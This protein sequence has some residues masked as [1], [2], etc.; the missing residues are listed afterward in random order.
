MLTNVLSFILG[1]A[2][3]LFGMHEMGKG[4]TAASGGKLEKILAKLTS[5]PIRGVLLGAA[6]TAIIQSSSAT[7]VMVVGFVNSGI[8]QLRQAVGVIMGANIGTTATSWILSL[9]GIEG[10]NLFLELCKPTS[11]S[12]VLAVI[13]VALVMFA[14]RER[15]Q[16]VGSILVG[17]A[18]LMTGMS[19][20]SDAV[21]PL[22]DVPEFTSMLTLF[23]NPFFGV[24]AGTLLT[25]IIQSSSASVGILQALCSTGVVTYSTALPIIMGQNIG[26]CV[27]A[28]LS[29]VGASKNA[30]RAAFVHLYFNLIGTVVFMSIV[31]TV[32]FVS[33]LAFFGE[34]A[35]ALGIAILH[36]VFNVFTTLLLLPFNRQLEK[37]ACFTVPER[38]SEGT[39]QDLRELDT[40]FLDKPALALDQSEKAVYR[41]ADLSRSALEKSFALFSKYDEKEAEQV[42]LMETKADHF[43]DRLGSYLVQLSRM[44]LSETASRRV[45]VLLHDI[46]DFER[47]TD[48]AKALA[49]SATEMNEKQIGFS[50]AALAELKAPMKEVQC[51][52]EGIVEELQ[53]SDYEKAKELAARRTRVAELCEIARAHHIERLK[54]GECTIEM[55]FILT[56]VCTNLRRT[57][58]H[59]MNIIN[60]QFEIYEKDLG[61]SIPTGQEV[62]TSK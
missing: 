37:L 19:M 27:T 53:G 30:R 28:L 35:D 43:E 58:D 60:C 31:Y 57:A 47:I 62:V 46:G 11:F 9:T 42:G 48:Y 52:A 29:S 13:G 41:M 51:L 54:N 22:K 44:P 16:S 32:N 10:D 34:Q 61:D 39:L 17:F 45:S 7:T 14:K 15:R 8:M 38:A 23:S 40:R 56:D 5:T 18:V 24:L 12:P 1:L 3:F 20:M 6:V 36:S 4:L 50:P 26:T 21:S 2:L 59:C 55:G 49:E 25:A 33:P